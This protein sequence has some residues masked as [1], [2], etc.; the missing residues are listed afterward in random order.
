[1]EGKRDIAEDSISET[2]CDAC[3][4]KRAPH[5]PRDSAPRATLMSPPLMKPTLTL[6]T[7]LHFALHP[8]T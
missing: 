1:M 6:L 7:Q 4:A 2:I 8:L 3:G 5:Q